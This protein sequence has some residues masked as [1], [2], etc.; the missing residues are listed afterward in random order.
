MCKNNHYKSY[1][2][3]ASLLSTIHS[4]IVHAACLSNRD[5]HS[6]C[7]PPSGTPSAHW[8]IHW[9]LGNLQLLYS[10]K[11]RE[12]RVEYWCLESENIVNQLQSLYSCKY[13]EN[14]V[15]YLS[16]E[17]V[18]KLYTA[19][20]GLLK[21][22][23]NSPVWGYLCYFKFTHS[24]KPAGRQGVIWTSNPSKINHPSG[25]PNIFEKYFKMFITII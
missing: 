21:I 3:S 17:S 22:S 12:N 25:H 18:N 10:C 24:S 14:R 7:L 5:L 9:N 23:L 4:T 13:R 11:E 8:W 16:S 6:P 20:F 1:N 19:L 15:V 2:A